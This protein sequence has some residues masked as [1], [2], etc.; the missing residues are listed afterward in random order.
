MAKAEKD[1]MM[2][3]PT[4][5][6][7]LS[8]LHKILSADPQRYLR[9]VNQWILENPKNAGAYFSRHFGWMD[10]GEPQRALEDL[11]KAIEHGA[12]PSSISFLL[13]GNVYRHL[14]EYQKALEDYGRGEALDPALWE[15]D[16]L[17]LFYQADAH[18]R[19]GDEGA[20][21]AYCARLPDGF[22]TPGLNGAP[23]GDKTQIA[24]QLRQIAANARRKQV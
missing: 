23:A 24:D 17:G 4:T 6:E 8:A 10:I 22:W 5:P 19:L 2:K 11:N 13:R 14:G 21:L 16:V 12:E 9:I 3:E 18:A 15:A 1:E 7:E 20:A